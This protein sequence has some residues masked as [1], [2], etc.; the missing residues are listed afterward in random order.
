MKAKPNFLYYAICA[1]IIFLI[2]AILLNPTVYIQSS[3]NGIILWAKSVLPALF[4]FFFLTKLLTNFNI[5][6]K[7]ANLSSFFTKKL[8][9]CS[10]I[11]NYVFLLSILS[12]YPI[13]AKLTAELYK[14]KAI[15][16]AEAVRMCS[17]CSTSGPIFV[18]G[19]VGAT[20][21]SSAKIGVII[22]VSHI[23]SAIINGMIF[24]FY[25]KNEEK[26]AVFYKKEA[27]L[28]N[29]LAETI[30]DSIISILIVGGYIALFYLLIDIFTNY[31]ILT[32]FQNCI[33]HILALA[34][35]DVACSF[36]LISGIIEI[37]R[38]CFE[39]SHTSNVFWSVIFATG[40]ISWG[41]FSIHLQSLTFLK[42]CNIKT[43]FFFFQKIIQTFISMVVCFVILAIFG[44]WFNMP[45][46][47][48][49]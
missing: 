19:T 20:M 12:G 32:L 9:N 28:Q 37:T 21:F 48:K 43:G 7:I 8:F 49:L 10:G 6:E 30:Y 26:T 38:G 5:V 29:I 17:F 42:Q 45:T 2:I 15:T 16:N 24:R 36:G 18:I 22:F 41:G 33:S 13:G 34:N 39:L 1:F 11:S 46:K 27:N 4:P 14:N 35:I 40:L 23:I 47:L 31:K 25:K 3:Y 44:I